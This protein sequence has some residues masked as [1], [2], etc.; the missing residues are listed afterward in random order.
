MGY[1]ISKHLLDLGFTMICCN[2]WLFRFFST[3]GWNMPC[4]QLSEKPNSSL[5]PRGQ[6]YE[7]TAIIGQCYPSN[8]QSFGPGYVQS[9]IRFSWRFMFLCGFYTMFSGVRCLFSIIRDMF[10]IWSTSFPFWRVES[11]LVSWWGSPWTTCQMR[12]PLYGHGSAIRWWG[13]SSSCL[14]DPYEHVASYRQKKPAIHTSFW[15]FG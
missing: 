5:S 9:F 15:E 13:A 6:N 1:D 4:H 11:T 14:L 7:H 10:N 8:S 12:P 3:M 2:S